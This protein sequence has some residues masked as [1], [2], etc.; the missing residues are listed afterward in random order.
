[1][2]DNKET[3]RGTDEQIL[4]E[5]K[6]TCE[7]INGAMAFGYQGT[8]P[9][10]SADY[11]LAPYWQ[12]GAR[13]RE[14]EQAKQAP[15][16]EA[17]AREILTACRD[18]IARYWEFDTS[19]AQGLITRIESALARASEA[20]AGEP[21]A[22]Q[23]LEDTNYVTTDKLLVKQWKR[24]GFRVRPLYAA[25]QPVSEQQ[26]EPLRRAVKAVVAMLK[27]GEYAE[28]WA[29]AEAPGDADVAGLE[30]AITELVNETHEAIEQQAARGLS[31]E[32][33]IKIAD[34]VEAQTGAGVTGDEH[35]IAFARALLAAKGDGHADE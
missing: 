8:N 4:F 19:K 21:V 16:V 5:R 10:P 22:W 32:E 27:D 30:A 20:A 15:A 17:G 24:S 13:M 31:D 34:R 11:W 3:K 9:P 18:A 7:A 28:H 23:S 33:I 35:V 12:H 1:M 25:P 26:G 2:T 6:L 14:L 29:N